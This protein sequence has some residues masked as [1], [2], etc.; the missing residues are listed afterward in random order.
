MKGREEYDYVKRKDKE[1]KLRKDET[2]GGTRTKAKKKKQMKKRRKYQNVYCH[3][4]MK[5]L[6]QTLSRPNFLQ[7]SNY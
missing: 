3:N 4:S 7:I 6:K 1:N 2:K 5:T